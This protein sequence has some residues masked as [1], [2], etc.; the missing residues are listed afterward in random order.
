[1]WVGDA[2]AAA[3]GLVRRVR[4]A[5]RGG[6]RSRER[7]ELGAHGGDRRA[8]RG[9]RPIALAA[10]QR[11]CDVEICGRACGVLVVAALIAMAVPPA[12]S[13]SAAIAAVGRASL[14]SGS[15]SGP[16]L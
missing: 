16:L 3:S 4:R 10:D 15:D 1:M 13:V 12:V 7:I 9:A 11:R 14:P 5:A 8:E 2:D 6:N